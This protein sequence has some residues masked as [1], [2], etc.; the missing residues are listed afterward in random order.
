MLALQE[1]LNQQSES[2]E[3]ARVTAQIEFFLRSGLGD[4]NAIQ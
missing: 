4:F 2:K 1:I 3:F